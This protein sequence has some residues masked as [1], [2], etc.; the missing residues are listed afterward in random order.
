MRQE[1]GGG[2]R[3]G[4]GCVAVVRVA[5]GREYGERQGREGMGGGKGGGGGRGG[6]CTSH[7]LRSIIG[8]LRRLSLSDSLPRGAL[9]VV[10]LCFVG[11]VGYIDYVTGYE[12]PL[13]LFYLLP[14]CL[15]VWFGNF[16]SD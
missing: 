9:I 14:I 7:Q 8:K 10:C 12:R 4:S 15:G 13:L 1:R 11:V 2:G 3:G 5:R 16:R 6:G